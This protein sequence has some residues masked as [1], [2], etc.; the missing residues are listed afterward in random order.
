MNDASNNCQL[1]RVK[2]PGQ[3]ERG[4]HSA[5]AP[6]APST[7]ETLMSS[8]LGLTWSHCWGR[9]QPAGPALEP[10]HVPAAASSP[11][12]SRAQSPFRRKEQPVGQVN[13]N[14]D[15]IKPPHIHGLTHRTACMLLQ[16]SLKPSKGKRRTKRP[17]PLT[18]ATL[19]AAGACSLPNPS[20]RLFTTR[21]DRCT[22]PYHPHCS[23]S[24]AG[25]NTSATVCCPADWRS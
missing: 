21:A 11:H 15:K 10:W 25:L 17:T 3:L 6:T 18:K 13:I 8:R 23:C 19:R 22:L 12:V 16:S 1:R 4:K 5:A 14:G 24:G 9:L 7:K 20:L 2:K